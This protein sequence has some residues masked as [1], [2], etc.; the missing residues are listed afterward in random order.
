MTQNHDTQATSTDIDEIA[1]QLDGLLNNELLSSLHITAILDAIK[2]LDPQQIASLCEQRPRL[3]AV[4]DDGGMGAGDGLPAPD[5]AEMGE[6][7]KRRRVYR[8]GALD[9]RFT[10]WLLGEGC[11]GTGGSSGC[12]RDW[13]RG[14]DVAIYVTTGGKLITAAKRWSRWVGEGER[15]TAAVHRTAENAIAWLREDS[16]SGELGPASKEAWEAACKE[17]PVLAGHDAEEVL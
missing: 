12:S 4:L 14:I 9:L 7:S 15:Y 17:W 11:H 5:P 8:D 1:E 10:G 2:G 6:P 13:H 3:R 16:S